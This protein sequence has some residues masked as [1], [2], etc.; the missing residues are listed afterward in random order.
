MVELRQ[1]LVRELHD[2]KSLAKSGM[3]VTSGS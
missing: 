2:N 3:V 1:Q